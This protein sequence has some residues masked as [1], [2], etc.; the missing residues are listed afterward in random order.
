MSFSDWMDEYSKIKQKEAVI[1][2]KDYPDEIESKEKLDDLIVNLMCEHGP[3][4][5]CDG[6]EIITQVIWN[7]IHK[8]KT[9]GS[10]DG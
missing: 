10:Q 5:H 4:G 7:I 1:I 2:S 8:T 3:D 6:H 9:R